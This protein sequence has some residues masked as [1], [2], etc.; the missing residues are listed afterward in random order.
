VQLTPF[1][2]FGTVVSQVVYEIRSDI[3]FKISVSSCQP[4]RLYSSTFGFELD[5]DL[6]AL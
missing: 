6:T 2:S 1:I 3:D 5:V 4:L